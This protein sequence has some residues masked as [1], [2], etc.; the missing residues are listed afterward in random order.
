MT[1]QIAIECVRVIERCAVAHDRLFRER[2]M[3]PKSISSLERVSRGTRRAL[4]AA[5]TNELDRRLLRDAYAWG[6]CTFLTV[7]GD[8]SSRCGLPAN[9]DGAH[10]AMCNL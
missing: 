7:H 10:V 5:A 8:G 2:E 4:V 3:D 6:Q 9:H 1:E